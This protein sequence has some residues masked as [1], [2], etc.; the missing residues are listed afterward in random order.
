MPWVDAKCPMCGF[1]GATF[2]RLDGLRQMC[3]ACSYEWNPNV[4]QPG[5]GE[6]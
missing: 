2:E 6:K 5:L 1:E 4:P 3:G